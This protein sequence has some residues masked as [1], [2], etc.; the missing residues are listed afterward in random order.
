MV[1]DAQQIYGRVDIEQGFFGKVLQFILII[2]GNEMVGVSEIDFR[3]LKLKSEIT[4]TEK[5]EK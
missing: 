2:R 1:L 3:N 4:K 5:K